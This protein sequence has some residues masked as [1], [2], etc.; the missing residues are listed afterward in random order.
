[1]DDYLDAKV[2]A[3]QRG[4]KDGSESEGCRRI[5]STF[6]EASKNAS[7]HERLQQRLSRTEIFDINTVG[8]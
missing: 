8:G 2:F 5:Q 4:T 6:I 1:M 7:D 3:G